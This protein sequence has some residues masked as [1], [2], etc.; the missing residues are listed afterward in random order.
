MDV[1]KSLKVR[2]KSRTL[3]YKISWIKIFVISY[4]IVE[5]EY[6]ENYFVEKLITLFIFKYIY[7]SI[8][9]FHHLLFN[10]STPG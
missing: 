8:L 6:L 7:I 2:E 3:S 9:I 10:Y 5:R 1:D 4:Y